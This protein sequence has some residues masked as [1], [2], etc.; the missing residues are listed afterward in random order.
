MRKINFFLFLALTAS[1]LAVSSAF[2]QSDTLHLSMSR[3]WG[4]GGFGNDIQ[5]LFS[6]KVSGPVT[7]TRVEFYIDDT[8]I[9]EGTAAPFRIQFNTDDYTLG[10]HTL[11]AIGYTSNGQ[12]LRSNEIPANFVPSQ[13]VGKFI[14]PV[15]AVVVLAIVGSSLIPML[16]SRGRL[17]TIPLGAERKYGVS[18]GGICPKCRRPFVLPLFSMNM[19]FSK[20]ARCPYCGKWSVTRIQTL[21]KLREAEK[22]ELEWGKVEA[23]EPSEEERLRKELD[24]SKYQGT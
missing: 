3:D 22:Y 12:E 10:Q 21:A 6:M 24:D 13:S 2:A 19:G 8:R 23:A 5:G 1:I 16:L 4:Y 7:L 14:T 17:Q 15:L 11:Y 9:G 18:G 20:L